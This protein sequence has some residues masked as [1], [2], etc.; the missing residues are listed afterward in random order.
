MKCMLVCVDFSDVTEDV[1]ET[2]QRTAQAFSSATWLVHAAAPDP[3]FVG[4][5]AGPQVV[6]DDVAKHLRAEHRQLQDHAQRMRDAGIDAHA[7]L[8][9]GPTV[10]ALLAQADEVGAE[11]I[12]MGSHGHGA[13]R[14]VFVG[15]VSQGVLKRAA[16]PVLIVPH[17]KR[18]D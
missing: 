15:S 10:D 7:L 16:C 9:Q 5:E 17:P 4:Y 12:V 6:R 1:L 11:L 13:L 18:V 3:D 2:A 8:I 14:R